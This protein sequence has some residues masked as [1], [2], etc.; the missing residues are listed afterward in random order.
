MQTHRLDNDNHTAG[1][2]TPIPC[3]QAQWRRNETQIAIPFGT[4]EKKM[5]KRSNFF[6]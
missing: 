3:H 4:V 2:R 6:L 5:V 1:Q